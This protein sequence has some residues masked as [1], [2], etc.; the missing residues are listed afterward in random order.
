M[1]T[2]RRRRAI[3]HWAL[4]PG[5]SIVLHALILVVLIVVGSRLTHAPPE[6]ARPVALAEI[7]R[8]PAPAPA[9]ERAEPRADPPAP[10]A[11]RPA[12]P[13][14][15]TRAT[16][17]DAL[18]RE[19]RALGSGD[20]ERIPI[21]ALGT[22]ETPESAPL[23]GES[24]AREAPVRFAGAPTGAA[25]RIVYCVD[26]SGATATSFSY[27]TQRLLQSIDMLSPTQR[28]RVVLFRERAGATTALVPDAD[29]PLVRATRANK[30][31]VAR[32]LDRTPAAGRSNPLD[33]LRAALELEPDLVLLISRA[34]ERTGDDPWAGGLATVR[35]RSRRSTRSTRSAARA[36]P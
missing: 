21:D 5:V 3:T 18:A 25:G 10:Q 4:P 22:L 14:R 17:P 33:G 8:T 12:R 28:F 27:I 29:E 16:E 31:R 23:L 1:P 34:I 9:P 35:R 13:A 19:A 11:D 20:R 2:R 7:E 30:A 15:D 6:R 32:R 36:R 26:A 24:P